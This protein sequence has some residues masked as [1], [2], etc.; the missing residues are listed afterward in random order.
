GGDVRADAGLAEVAGAAVAGRV[1]GLL[2][3]AGGAIL[4]LGEPLLGQR[5]HPLP[6]P[7]LGAD[8]VLVGERLEDRIDRARARPPGAAAGALQP[9]AELVAVRRPLLQRHEERRA[10]VA[11]APAGACAAGGASL[12]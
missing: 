11:V 3:A 5:V 6:I 8:A 10:D 12:L 4:D 2:L 9:L 1:P 7:F